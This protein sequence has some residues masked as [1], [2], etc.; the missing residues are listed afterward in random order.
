MF[1]SSPQKLLQVPCLGIP[2]VLVSGQG[3]SVTVGG[4]KRENFT[5]SSMSL[6][7]NTTFLKPEKKWS[8][9]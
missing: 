8:S 6:L 1:P 7:G 2:I 4:G 9:G 5:R 3:R